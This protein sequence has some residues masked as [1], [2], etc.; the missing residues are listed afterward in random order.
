MSELVNPDGLESQA[1]REAGHVLMAYLITHAGIAD[2]FFALPIQPA[3]RGLLVPE[4]DLISLNGDL[5]QL[6]QPSF[7]LRSLI[8]MPLFLLGGV[9]A[10]RIRQGTPKE[11]PLPESPAISRAMGMLAS[12]F[13]EYGATESQ[14]TEGRIDMATKD[15]YRFA[16]RELRNQWP[17]LETFSLRLQEKGSLSRH[18][19]F[20]FF[21]SCIPEENQKPRAGSPATRALTGPPNNSMEPTRPAGC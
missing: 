13:E 21:D 9:A 15:F 2:H 20:A 11:V 14:G 12:Y 5:S 10:A 19:A 3:D 17:A 4:F 18:D 6:A 7:S 16:E 1:Y 8:T